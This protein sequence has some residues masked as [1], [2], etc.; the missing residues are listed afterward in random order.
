MNAAARGGD[1]FQLSRAAS[2]LLM[3]TVACALAWAFVVMASPL[4][5]DDLGLLEL[6]AR[7]PFDTRRDLHGRMHVLQADV[8]YFAP[9]V[10]RDGG[11]PDSLHQVWEDSNRLTDISSVMSTLT[12]KRAT[13]RGGDVQQ[14]IGTVFVT[15]DPFGDVGDLILDRMLVVSRLTGGT[16]FAFGLSWWCRLRDGWRRGN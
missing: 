16:F 10:A 15:I 11:G 3:I 7:P 12:R 8:K 4:R 14:G 5:G 9:Q 1:Q 2:A 6:H 13:S